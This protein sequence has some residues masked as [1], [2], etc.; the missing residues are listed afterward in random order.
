[1]ILRCSCQEGDVIALGIDK[2]ASQKQA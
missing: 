1:M 2:L